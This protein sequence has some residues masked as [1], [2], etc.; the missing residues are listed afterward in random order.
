MP[1]RTRAL[2]AAILIAAST[3]LLLGLGPRESAAHAP[4]T[5][6]VPRLLAATAERQ[7]TMPWY[8]DVQADSGEVV[9]KRSCV[10]C[11]EKVDVNGA[12][13]RAKWTG[14]PVYRLFERIRSSMPDS[15]PG[16][17][18]LEDYT[19]V[20]AYVLKLNGIPATSTRLVPDSAALEGAK[21]I[22]AAPAN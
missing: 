15:D 8:L 13:F 16:S 1:S 5:D 14:R 18:P 10:E 3:G 7:D 11:H 19:Y 22:I 2:G 21:L 17:L 6:V 20:V 4:R 9:F 12:D